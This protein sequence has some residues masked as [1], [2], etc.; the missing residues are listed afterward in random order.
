[1]E[2]SAPPPVCRVRGASARAVRPLARGLGL[3]VAEQRR[4]DAEGG[5]N[6]RDLDVAVTVG[7]SLD[8]RR[9]GQDPFGV[10]EMLSRGSGSL[11]CTVHGPDLI[12]GPGPVVVM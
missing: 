7:S 11:S 6:E 12:S 8:E 3:P 5:V 2:E 9:G 1:V 10:G 4:G